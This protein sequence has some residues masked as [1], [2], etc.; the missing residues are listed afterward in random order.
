MR[1]QLSRKQPSSDGK[2]PASTAPRS[3][4]KPCMERIIEIIKAVADADTT[5]LVTGETGTGKDLVARKIHEWSSRRAILHKVNCAA[6]VP[7]LIESELF[8]HEKG[9]FTGAAARKIG[10]FELA[11]NSTL[12]LD[13]IG[14]LP[15]Q[16]RQSCCRFCRSTSSSA[17]AA[18]KPFVPMLASS[19]QPITTSARWWWRQGFVRTCSTGS[20][21]SPCR[22]A[23]A[24]TARGYSSSGQVLR[25]AV[26]QSFDG[27]S[28]ASTKAR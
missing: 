23:P 12:F 25:A 8:G 4:C 16:R 17:W 18:R 9:A 21:S 6:L 24:G 20:I 3:V 1:D 11:Q 7:T 14:E 19:R 10:R 13:E 27:R 15:L 28:P 5:V 26:A 22:A 2:W